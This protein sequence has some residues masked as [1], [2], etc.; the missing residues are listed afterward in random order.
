M[1]GVPSIYLHFND[2]GESLLSIFAKQ[3]QHQLV[4]TLLIAHPEL[5]NHA[6]YG[7]ALGGHEEHVN[8]L[9]NEDTLLAPKAVAGYARAGLVL[10]VR[11]LIIKYPESK[12]QS[13]FGYAQS[14]NLE[15]VAAALRSSKGYLEYAIQGCASTNRKELLTSLLTGSTCYATAIT[16]AA[17]SGHQELVTDLLAQFGIKYNEPFIESATQASKAQALLLNKALSGFIL[18]SHFTEAAHLIAMGADAG[19][20]VEQLQQV[21]G[22]FKDNALVLLSHIPLKAVRTEVLKLILSADLELNPGDFDHDLIE[23][24]SVSI[25]KGSNYLAAAPLYNPQDKIGIECGG[26]M[27]LSLLEKVFADKIEPVARLRCG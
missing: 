13:V 19:T 14:G 2:N 25:V 24:I 21:T 1:A 11:E 6:A 8:K 3:G 26:L 12:A 4:D 23:N 16:E 7:Y 20:A 10:K 17:V 22:S 5:K 9:L 27:S 15:Q 18:G